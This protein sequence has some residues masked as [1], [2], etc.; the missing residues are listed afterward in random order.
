MAVVEMYVVKIRLTTDGRFS[1]RLLYDAL[2]S[3]VYNAT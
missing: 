1:W 2:F 3:L